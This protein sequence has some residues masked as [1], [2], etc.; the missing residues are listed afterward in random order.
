MLSN[1]LQVYLIL[2]AL[3]LAAGVYGLVQKRSF[4]GMLISIE[5]I[6]NGAGLNCMAFNRFC[7]PDPAIG[8]VLTLFI[9]GIAAAEAAIGVG[10]IL[11]VYKRF[12]TID[13]TRIFILKQ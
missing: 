8:Q 9:M 13:P 7:S 6:L 12:R 3:L 2:A 11:A 1:G 10:F 5:L 4:I